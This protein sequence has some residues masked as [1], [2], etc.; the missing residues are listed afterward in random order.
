MTR[1]DLARQQVLEAASA[2]LKE[3]PGAEFA[4]YV[5]PAPEVIGAGGEQ[6]VRLQVT[7]QVI[8]PR[9]ELAPLVDM[10]GV[11]EYITA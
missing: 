1:P 5:F 9:P 2:W 4:R 8:K 3:N 11:T 6:A 7:I 10:A